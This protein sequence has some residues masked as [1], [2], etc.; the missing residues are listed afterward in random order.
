MA[1]HE[2]KEYERMICNGIKP[3]PECGTRYV[4]IW[5]LLG[6]LARKEGTPVAQLCAHAPDCIESRTSGF[7]I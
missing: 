1:E 5:N 2:K 6:L 7:R 3:K 4:I